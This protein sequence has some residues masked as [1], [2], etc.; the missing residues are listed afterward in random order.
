MKRTEALATLDESEVSLHLVLCVSLKP[1][2]F[3]SDL[4]GFVITRN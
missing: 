1:N 3:K 4:I 2:L